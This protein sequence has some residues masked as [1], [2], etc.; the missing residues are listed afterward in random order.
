MDIENLNAAIAIL[1]RHDVIKESA[2]KYR[3]IVELFRRWTISVI[4]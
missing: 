2:G 3:I 4:S 1:E